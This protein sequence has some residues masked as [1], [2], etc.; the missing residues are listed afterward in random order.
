[1]IS[2]Y[3]IRV[4]ERRVGEILVERLDPLVGDVKRIVH[5]VGSVRRIGRRFRREVEHRLLADLPRRHLFEAQLDAGQR[6][7][8]WLQRD[9][10]LEIARRDDGDR[11][12]LTLGLPPVDLRCFVRREIVGLR[13]GG[14]HELISQKACHAQARPEAQH[15]S[16]VQ[17][18]NRVD[19]VRGFRH[20]RLLRPVSPRRHPFDAGVCAFV[21]SFT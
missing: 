16:T 2:Y 1:M 17:P 7:E 4:R 6:L 15:I 11:D 18:I 12:L 9:E 20:W 8:L 19:V 13:Q 5:R 3:L 10:V 21:Y 14:G